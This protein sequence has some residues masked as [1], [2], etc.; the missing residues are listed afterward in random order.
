M[1]LLDGTARDQISQAFPHQLEAIKYW[2]REW[3]GN[4]AN[5]SASNGAST[6]HSAI[7]CSGPD[8]ECPEQ[9]NRTVSNF[10]YLV[11]PGG[12]GVFMQELYGDE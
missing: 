1:C 5:L 3:P 11:Q 2:Q 9:L 8:V 6:I 10:R 7:Q 4:E 12:A